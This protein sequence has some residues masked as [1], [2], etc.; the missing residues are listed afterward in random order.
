M[1]VRTPV[2]LELLAACLHV[3]VEP[4]ATEVNLPIAVETLATKADLHAADLSRFMKF[5][6]SHDALTL[7]FLSQEGLGLTLMM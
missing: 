7:V 4:P 3:M 6:Q 5:A 1:E 2:R